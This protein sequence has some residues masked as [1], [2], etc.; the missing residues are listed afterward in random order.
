M[1]KSAEF[2]DE[3]ARVVD[4]LTADLEAGDHDAPRFIGPQAD[5][6]HHLSSDLGAGR[7]GV[8]P[9]ALGARAGDERRA[10]PGVEGGAQS[11]AVEVCWS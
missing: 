6:A 9:R 5:A 7:I 1:P 4:L 11:H 8:D 2:A 3:K 10:A